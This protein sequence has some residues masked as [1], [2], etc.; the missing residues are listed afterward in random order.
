MGDEM[1]DER[2]AK[3]AD[4]LRAIDAGLLSRFRYSATR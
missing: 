3:R 2:A 1:Y 4:T